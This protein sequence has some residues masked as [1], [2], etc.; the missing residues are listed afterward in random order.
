MNTRRILVGVGVTATTLLVAGY[1]IASV[2]V[3]NRLTKIGAC[4]AAWATNVPNAFGVL[5]ADGTPNPGREDFDAAPYLMPEPED[6]MIPSR[7]AGIELSGWY[8]PAVAAGAPVVVIAHGLSACR[9][10][11]TVLVPAGMLHR[12]GFAVLLVD[13]R[14]HGDSTIEDGHYAG[15]TEEYRDLLGV[16]DWLQADRG[17]AP[18]RIGLAGISLGAATSLIATGHEPLVAAVWADSSFADL[19][20]FIRDELSRQ[21]YPTFLDI[22]AV[23][24]GR[25]IRGDDLAA[26]SPLR[27]VRRLAGRPI[28][29][30]H[31]ERDD[32]VKVADG[33]ALAA[34]VEADGGVAGTWFVPGSGHTRAMI[35][36]PDEYERRLVGFFRE[37]LGG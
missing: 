17:F 16:W 6:V 7:D 1:G 10:D 32:V 5:A 31:G 26:D 3:Y 9:R 12:N 24:A 34:A 23:L 15:G 22:G 11:A 13:L 37:A 2:V 19:P 20:A 33:R 25:I 27:N 36:Q 4:P 21:G 28:Y 30:T 18:E 8:V 14:E 35:D 29:I